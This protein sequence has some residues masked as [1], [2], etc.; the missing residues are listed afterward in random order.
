MR[1][2]LD[3]HIAVWAILQ[4]ERLSGEAAR[5]IVDPS[6]S[7]YV[8]VVGLWEIAIKRSTGRQA[9]G[10][11]VPPVELAA[12]EFAATGFDLLPI[13]PGQ[14]VRI[15]SMPFHHRDP[16]DRLMVAQAAAEGMTFLTADAKLAAY[17]DTVRVM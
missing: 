9:L 10:D 13:S 11:P 5:W 4:P 12:A 2:L 17:G 7:I 1:I 16:F 6:N 15:E 14:L 8:S 3:T